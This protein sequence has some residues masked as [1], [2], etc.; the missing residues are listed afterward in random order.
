MENYQITTATRNTKIQ[1]NPDASLN[2]GADVEVFGIKLTGVIEK[3]NN[4][5]RILVCPTSKNPQQDVTLKAILGE[6]GIT[7]TSQADDV[8]K[9]VGFDGGADKVD[10]KVHQAFFY[11]SNAEA[12]IASITVPDKGTVKIDRE[13][14]F[15][16]GMVNTFEPSDNAK[17]LPF[18]IDSISFSLWNSTRKGVVE[19]LGAYGIADKL[20]K[21]S[22]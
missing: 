3:N 18:K 12:D 16:L 1:V 17:K 15:S 13:Y 11:S 10:I 14:A 9:F 2:F 8:L 19:S 6:L 20:D 4:D 22:E 21:L 7:D 5:V